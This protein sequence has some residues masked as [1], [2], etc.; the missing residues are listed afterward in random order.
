MRSPARPVLK[1]LE[2]PH[3]GPAPNSTQTDVTAALTEASNYLR[4]GGTWNATMHWFVNRWLDRQLE[5]D[6]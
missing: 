4:A 6:R 5:L 2:Q 1:P 3:T